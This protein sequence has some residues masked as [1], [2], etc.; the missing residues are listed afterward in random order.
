MGACSLP[1]SRGL[2]RLTCLSWIPVDLGG[3]KPRPLLP[4]MTDKQK[5][6]FW[7]GVLPL[8]PQGLPGGPSSS[9]L[10]LP[11]CW[12]KSLQLCALSAGK[13]LGCGKAWAGSSTVQE[14][15][16]RASVLWLFRFPSRK[17]M[18]VS[19]SMTEEE[20]TARLA[21]LVPSRRVLLS[22]GCP[23][24]QYTQPLLSHPLDIGVSWASELPAF[25]IPAP[26]TT[27]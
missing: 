15:V 12:G 8:A 14:C 22:V 25:T 18:K 4:T 13:G 23:G 7:P 26:E 3:Q 27:E 21:K 17:E 24:P 1:S 6:W 20:P 9:D 10:H 2:Q 19:F 11:Y 5:R 16:V